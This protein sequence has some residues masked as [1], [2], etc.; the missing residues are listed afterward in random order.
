MRAFTG[1]RCGALNEVH[2][3]EAQDFLMMRVGLEV[4]IL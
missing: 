1:G 3:E 4:S 2:A